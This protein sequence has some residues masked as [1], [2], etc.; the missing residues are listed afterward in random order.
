M[1][2]LLRGRK[3]LRGL[4]WTS[5]IVLTVFQ[6]VCGRFARPPCHEDTY[7]DVDVH[8]QAILCETHTEELEIKLNGILKSF[9]QGG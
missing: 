5:R 7:D 1:S 9:V 3:C 8:D 6:Y 2:D 4:R